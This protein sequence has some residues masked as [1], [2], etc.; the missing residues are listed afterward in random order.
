MQRDGLVDFDVLVAG[1]FSMVK[2]SKQAEVL[3]MEVC[4]KEHSERT[5][6]EHVTRERHDQGLH[7][8]IG[9]RE[10]GRTEL[11]QQPARR[12]ST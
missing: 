8:M 9:D 12:A 1:S 11:Q 4:G 7:F 3:M 10:H 5:A 2:R 6:T